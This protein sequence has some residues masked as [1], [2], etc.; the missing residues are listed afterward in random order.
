MLTKEEKIKAAAHAFRSIE[1][2]KTGAHICK[3]IAELAFLMHTLGEKCEGTNLHSYYEYY[4]EVV[5]NIET[6]VKNK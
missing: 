2:V 4:K 5:S 1:A 6:I 3:S